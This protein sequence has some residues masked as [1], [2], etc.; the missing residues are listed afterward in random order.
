MILQTAEIG[1]M[2]LKSL[3]STVLE[4]FAT[5]VTIVRRQSSGT[6]AALR[7]GFTI[8]ASTWGYVEAQI[9]KNLKEKPIRASILEG[10]KT[11]QGES[12]FQF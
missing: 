3:G 12:N 9:V 7:E 8:L 6:W 11:V 10:V 1:L 2:G 5:G 4:D